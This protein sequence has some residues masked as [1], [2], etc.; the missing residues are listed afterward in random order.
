MSPIKIAELRPVSLLLGGTGRA[1]PG[2][3][4]E[5]HLAALLVPSSVHPNARTVSPDGNR[6]A[7][8]GRQ[9]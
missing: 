1:R 3:Q 6:P 5:R 8:F 7:L 9:D 4:S 2:V